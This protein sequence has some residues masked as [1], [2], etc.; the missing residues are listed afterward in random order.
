MKGSQ[1]ELSLVR[2]APVLGIPV[3]SQ[4]SVV[5]LVAGGGDKASRTVGAEEFDFNPEG[6]RKLVDIKTLA[7]MLVCLEKYT[8]QDYKN[9]KLSEREF[10]NF[11]NTELA[12]FTKKRDPRVL[13]YM[14]KKLDLN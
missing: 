12:V 1:E 10:L 3:L 4:T 9:C 5:G 13:D 2:R 6:T 14:M 7:E 11:N 8:G